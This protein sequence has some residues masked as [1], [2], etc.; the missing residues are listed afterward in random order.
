MTTFALLA[1]IYSSNQRR[2]IGETLQTLLE[3][4]NVEATVTGEPTENWVQVTLSGE[5]EAVATNLL[6]REFGFCPTKL[7]NIEKASTL[8]GFVTNLK[9]NK[10]ELSVDVG[11]FQP[12]TVLATIP[13]SHLQ[14]KLAGGKNTSLEIAEFWGICEHLPLNVK[15][16]EVNAEENRIDAELSAEQVAK[17]FNWRDS[18]LDRLLILGASLDQVKMAVEQ[19]EL[20]R[21]VINIDALGMFEHALVCKLGTDAAGLIPR[22]GRRM[23]KAAFTVF[24]PRKL[25]AFLNTQQIAKST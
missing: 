4:L 21:D 19:A 17:F 1:K 11:V 20:D 14:A 8:R 10:T 16:V 22:L 7:E 2:Q 13:L 18:L 6:A 24:S 9:K 23:R 12:K 15:V 25:N 3:G 5:D